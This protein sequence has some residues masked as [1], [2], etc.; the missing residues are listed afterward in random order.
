MQD[1]YKTNSFD[2]KIA[3]EIFDAIGTCDHICDF[4]AGH[5]ELANFF[6][7]D[8]GKNYAGIDINH[9]FVQMAN[10]SFKNNI[11]IKFIYSSLFDFENPNFDCVVCSRLIH[12]FSPSIFRKCIRKM[13][14]TISFQGRLIIVDSVRNYNNR[15]DRFLYLPKNCIYEVLQNIS[16]VPYNQERE[17]II[18]DNQYWMLTAD[19]AVGFLSFKTTIIG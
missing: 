10:D 12:H 3:S 5:T 18:S 9:R 17:I 15:T 1:I 13:I 16:N 19:I 6:V 11:N 14:E 8:A 7:F 2:R 4:G